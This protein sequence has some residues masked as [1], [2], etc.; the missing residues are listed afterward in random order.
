MVVIRVDG[1]PVVGLGHVRRCLALAAELARTAEVRFL[2]KGTEEVASLVRREGFRCDLLYGDFGATLAAIAEVRPT[3]LVIDSY[4]AA[5][6]HY[7][8]ARSRVRL[9]VAL[10]DFGRNPLPADMVVNATPGVAAPTGENGTRYLVGP[11]FALLGREFACAVG[12]EVLEQVRGVLLILGGASSAPLMTAL[13]RVVRQALSEATA[14]LVVGPAGD[15][16]WKVAAG[17]WGVDGVKIHSAPES[18]RP[19]MLEA[20]LAVTGGGVTA[21]ELAATGTPAVGVELGPNQALNLAGFAAAGTLRVAGRVGDPSLAVS[22]GRALRAMASDV[23]GRRVMS[24][25]GRELVDGGGARRVAEAILAYL[26]ERRPVTEP[27]A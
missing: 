15:R 7:A 18:V 21:F 22:V 6:D 20:D 3:V 12:R 10:D 14:H 8:S 5:A 9:L 19:L 2:L 1:G 26:E 11:R 4:E 13:T 23:D 16:P 25:R 27:S 24:L 17:L